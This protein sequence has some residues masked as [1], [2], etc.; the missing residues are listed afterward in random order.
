MTI[1]WWTLGL[2]TVNVLILIWILARFLFRP[3]AK[4]IAERQAAAHAALDQAQAARAEAEA[5]RDTAKAETV[6]IAQTRAELLAKAQDEAKREREHLLAAARTEADK[7]RADARAELERIREDGRTAITD[8]AAALA[9]DIAARLVGRLPDTA[10]I[11]GFIDGLVT[12]VTDLPEATRGGIG[13]TGPVRLRAARTLTGG[14][15]A[16]LET[17]LGEALGH[18]VTLDIAPDPALIAGL[19]LDAPHAV[20]RNHFRADLDRIAA[21][22]A[23]DD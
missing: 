7:A 9:A 16:R 11:D 21:E 3:V 19:E 4:I 1:D 20:V 14:E 17:R 13:A 5:A 15:R 8:E 18:A 10:R 22:L 12:A 6:A 2:Q 23:R